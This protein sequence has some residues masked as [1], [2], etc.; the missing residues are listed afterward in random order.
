MDHKDIPHIFQIRKNKSFFDIKTERNDIPCIFFSESAEVG[1]S[2]VLKWIP[3][4]VPITLLQ[5]EVFPQK[6][7]VV[8]HLNDERNIKCVLKISE[9][10]SICFI[11]EMM[12]LLQQMEPNGRNEAPLSLALFLYINKI[13]SLFHSCR[14]F[15]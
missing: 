9:K 6:F 13:F 7:F 2:I 11:F 4:I 8:C 15:L 5:S 12:T 1:I 3:E 10:Y 14:G